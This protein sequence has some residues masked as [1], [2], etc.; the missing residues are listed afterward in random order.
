LSYLT[1]KEKIE[2]EDRCKNWDNGMWI[3]NLIDYIEKLIKTKIEEFDY[4]N[5]TMEE[6]QN[7]RS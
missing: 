5:R 3:E 7:V 6:V 4:R 1:A 2:I